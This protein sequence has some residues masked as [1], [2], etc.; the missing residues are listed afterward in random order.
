[1]D[2]TAEFYLQTIDQVFVRHLCREGR[3]GRIAAAASISTAIKRVALMTVE[4]E[5]DDITGVGQ[6]RGRTRPVQRHPGRQQ[7]ALRVPGRRPLRHLQRLALPLRDRA[8]HRRLRASRR[9]AGGW[10]TRVP[11]IAESA[12]LDAGRQFRRLRFGRVRVRAQRRDDCDDRERAGARYRR[13]SAGAHR[14]DDRGSLQ[15][16]QDRDR[17][18]DG[19]LDAAVVFARQPVPRRTCC[20]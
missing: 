11:E 15:H 13:R 18:F 6:C 12:S 3:D 16:R 7:D 2:L 17:H 5:K 10:R 14:R 4:G 1:M 19:V 9:S 8:A 20:A